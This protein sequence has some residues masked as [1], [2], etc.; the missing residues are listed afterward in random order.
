MQ[1]GTV[2]RRNT[3]G[4]RSLDNCLA[5]LNASI[6]D[7]IRC[8]HVNGLR[9]VLIHENGVLR[10]TVTDGDIRRAILANVSLDSA[11]QTIMNPKPMVI[12]ASVNHVRALEIMRRKAIT[13]LPV[14]D[15]TGRIID[16]LE[17]RQL[18]SEQFHRNWVVLMAGG[19]GTRLRPLTETIPKP[20]VVVGGRPILETTIIQFAGQGFR[21]LFVSVNYKA[22]II[23]SY[24]GNGQRYNADIRYLRETSKL[25][26]AGALSL[27]PHRPEYP[28]IV[29]NGDI[30]TTLW[31]P[32]LVEAHEKSGALATVALTE[33]TYT[34]PFG[35]VSVD[36]GKV[37]RI[38]EK[39]SQKL[40]VNSGIY[41]LSP[42][43]WDWI[44]PGEPLDMPSLLARMLEAGAPV[45]AW[46]IEGYW[47]DIG[48]YEDLGVAN[49]KFGEI[50]G[51]IG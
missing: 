30:L 10:G 4:P 17:M 22:E 7:V 13:V 8:L 28:V 33:H 31:F 44:K 15:S 49:A 39:P 45:G 29:M 32:S 2:Q 23:E 19:L 40:K 37:A 48:R 46:Q 26:T 3:G 27:L 51:E 6:L 16:L 9:I 35:V 47:T 12:D 18:L 38:E 25:G 20:M 21:E 42:E 5:D 11:A 14:L 50:F 1:D 24:F 43:A 34:V 36:G 41:V